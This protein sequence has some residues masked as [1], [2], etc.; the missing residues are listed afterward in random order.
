VRSH[1]VVAAPECFDHDLGIDPVL[2]PLHRQALV[3]VGKK[4]MAPE[5]NVSKLVVNEELDWS[6]ITPVATSFD[7]DTAKRLY[8][9]LKALDALAVELTNS[10][11]PVP[12]IEK[13][14]VAM[15]T[16]ISYYE[17]KH[18]LDSPGASG[19]SLAYLKAAALCWILDL[20]EQKDAIASLRLKGAKSVRLF[21]LVENFW[22]RRP[23]DRIALPPIVRDY[24]SHR[25]QTVKNGAAI[26]GPSLDIGPQ[27]KTLDARLE[28]RWRGAWQA[29]RSEN[30]DKV[31]QAA[32][33]MVEVLDKV[34]GGIC[35]DRPFRDVLAERYPKQEKVIIAQRATISALK[36][37][38]H[39]IKHETHAQSVHIAEDIMHAAEGII[40]TLLR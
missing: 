9:G 37:S 6:R 3:A 30:P 18:H 32:N 24:V 40:R 36:E 16:I 23:F 31:S 39:S 26:S 14:H 33:S 35:G 21:E 2:E 22:L 5:V 11:V 38:L 15:A 25:P 17:E 29:L 13:E 28:E 27:L 12:E 10:D 1:L 34:I 7:E 8:E 4:G 20:E 19:N